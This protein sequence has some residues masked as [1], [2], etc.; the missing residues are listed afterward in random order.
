MKYF[1]VEGAVGRRKSTPIYLEGHSEVN[2]VQGL[3]DTMDD[4]REIVSSEIVENGKTTA[5]YLSDGR[6]ILRVKETKVAVKTRL[7][8]A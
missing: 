7:A 2:A 5:V 1:V 4:P 3:L 8:T 6:T